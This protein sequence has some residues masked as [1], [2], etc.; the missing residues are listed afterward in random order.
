M[1]EYEKALDAAE[2]NLKAGLAL[3]QAQKAGLSFIKNPLVG[4][5]N[6]LAHMGIVVPENIYFGTSDTPGVPPGGY[7][8]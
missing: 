8:F 3:I 6:Y 5:V 4:T 1:N 7:G 2:A